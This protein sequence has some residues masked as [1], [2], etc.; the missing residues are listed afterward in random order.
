M[1][2]PILYEMVA[3]PAETPVITPVVLPTVVTTAIDVDDVAQVPP[4][5]ASASVVDLPVH[6]DMI[7]VSPAGA[8]V[9]VSVSVAAQLPML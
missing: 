1:H 5:V 8:G 7:P 9:T 4:V 3:V 6:N 2:P